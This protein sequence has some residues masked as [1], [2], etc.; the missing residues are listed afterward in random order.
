MSNSVELRLGESEVLY[1][2]LKEKF[3]LAADRHMALKSEF[4]HAKTS[5]RKLTNQ[6]KYLA[7]VLV[8]LYPHLVVES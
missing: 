2:E 7:D 1:R 3:L 8:E 5:R 4:N 6:V